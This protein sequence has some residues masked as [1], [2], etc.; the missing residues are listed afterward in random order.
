MK[1]IRLS[2]MM[3]FMFASLLSFAES[4]ETFHGVLD[5][6]KQNDEVERVLLVKDKSQK[7][8]LLDVHKNLMA[9]ARLNRGKK[10]TVKGVQ[11]EKSTSNQKIVGVIKVKNIAPYR[12]KSF[13]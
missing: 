12:K 8:Y 5:M 13:P 11:V 6:I 4:V 7:I 2:L 10:V 1:T 9:V 3:S